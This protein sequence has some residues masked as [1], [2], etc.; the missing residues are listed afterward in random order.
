MKLMKIKKEKKMININYRSNLNNN[1]K[2]KNLVIIIM[3][4][5]NKNMI[6]ILNLAWNHKKVT[7]NN[8]LIS[9]NNKI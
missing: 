3:H 5:I 8:H 2:I 1:D 7:N 6:I 4:K 9:F